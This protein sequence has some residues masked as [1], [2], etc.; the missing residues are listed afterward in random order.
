MI[1]FNKKKLLKILGL[2]IGPVLPMVIV[3]YFL[4]PYLNT[5]KYKEVVGKYKKEH[6]Q[7]EDIAGID[8]SGVDVIGEGSDSVRDRDVVGDKVFQQSIDRLKSKV[9]SFKAV[10]DSLHAL[11]LAKDEQIKKMKVQQRAESDSASKAT[12][13]AKIT[14]KKLAENMKSLL[15]LDIEQLAPIIREMSDRE[16]VRLY[17]NGSSIQ[18]RKL[19][20]SLKARRAAKLMK[21][22]L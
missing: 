2:I 5:T 11:L 3:A 14:D 10:N 17:E 4:F 15:R 22:V 12:K 21:E 16:V 20:Q 9:D 13:D 19:L 18:K 6:R 7:D 1:K 8:T